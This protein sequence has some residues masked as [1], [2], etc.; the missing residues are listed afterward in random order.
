MKLGMSKSR[1][2]SD[3]IRVKRSGIH[4]RG[5]FARKDIPEG[6]RVIEYV[7]DKV[8]KAES[9][10][11]AENQLEKSGKNGDGAVY[12]FIL[13]KRYDIDGNVSWNKARLANHSCD[14]NCETD[15]IKGRIWL[16]ALRDIEKGEEILYNY[17]FDLEHFEGHP[18]RCGAKKCVGYIVGN[19]YWSKLRKALKKKKKRKAKK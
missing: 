11:R 12:I 16:I 4:R 8:T 2:D 7:G 3:W 18:C 15:I 5:I 1:G 9:E 10:R 6:T 19:E 17:N 14:P 13:N